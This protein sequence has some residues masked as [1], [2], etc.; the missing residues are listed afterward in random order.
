[1]CEIAIYLN[2]SVF[3][4]SSIYI[5]IYMY[6]VE[7]NVEKNETN[8][9]FSLWNRVGTRGIYVR[10]FDIWSFYIVKCNLG[11]IGKSKI[12]LS[13]TN[14]RSIVAEYRTVDTKGQTVELRIFLCFFDQSFP[15]VSWHGYIFLTYRIIQ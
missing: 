13:P 10:R 6:F 5:E 15:T 4:N 12:I 14:D 3:G 7:K 9:V 2:L 11:N 8:I 1:M